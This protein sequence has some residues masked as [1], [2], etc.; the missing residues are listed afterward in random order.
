MPWKNGGGETTEIAISPAGAGLDGFDWRVSTARVASDGPFSRFPGIDRTLAVLAGAGLRLS[1]DGRTSVLLTSR[2]GPFAF[3]GDV[4]V[5]ATL[6]HGEVLDLNV[7]T[8]RDRCSH[9]INRIEFTGSAKL[10][11]TGAETLLY[12]AEGET[13]IET[14]VGSAVLGRSEALLSSSKG[15][16]SLTANGDALAYSIEFYD[17]STTNC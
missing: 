9:S 13:L 4:D 11:A 1:V 15:A 5:D 8:R 14:P 2:T 10:A 7:M 3:A 6:V 12:C 16:W 17:I